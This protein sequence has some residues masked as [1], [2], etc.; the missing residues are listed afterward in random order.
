MTKGVYIWAFLLVCVSVFFSTAHLWLSWALLFSGD[1]AEALAAWKQSA[2]INTGVTHPMR[3]IPEIQAARLT[4]ENVKAAT[5]G[6]RRPAV[7][8]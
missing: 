1:R 7:I 6:Y 4:L 2:P 3:P 8:R 5:D